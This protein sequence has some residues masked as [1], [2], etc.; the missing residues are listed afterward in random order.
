MEQID[1]YLKE[2]Y[3]VDYKIK[4]N[5]NKFRNTFLENPAE[6]IADAKDIPKARI[7]NNYR[8]KKCNMLP[9]RKSNI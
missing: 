4:K 9:K 6:V 1:Q 8:K 2:A 7:L 5:P 3:K